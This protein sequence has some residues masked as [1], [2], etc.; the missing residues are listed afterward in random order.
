MP[1]LKDGEDAPVE[2]GRAENEMPLDPPGFKDDIEPDVLA[3][4]KRANTGLGF[5]V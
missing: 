2:G 3:E 5:G 4:G 1:G